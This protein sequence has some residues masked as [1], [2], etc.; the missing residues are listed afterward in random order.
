VKRKRGQ[1]PPLTP[2]LQAALAAERA[3]VADLVAGETEPVELEPYYDRV[4]VKTLEPR[5]RTPGGI[6]VPELAIE[7]TPYRYGEVKAVGHGRMT[8]TGDVVPMK[9]TVGDVVMFV[10][11]NNGEQFPLPALDGGP[12]RWLVIRE[13]HVVG[14]IRNPARLSAIA[15][16]AGEGLIS[17]AS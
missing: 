17:P 11:T 13:P 12:T 4:V 16:P 3:R 2:E 14:T 15:G 7:N 5:Q 10:K 6:I 8:A 9:V 1:M